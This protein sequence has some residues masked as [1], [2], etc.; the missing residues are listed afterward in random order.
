[1]RLG[2]E[3]LGAADSV[4]SVQEIRADLTLL[5]K[6]IEEEGHSVDRASRESVWTHWQETNQRAW[7][8]LNACWRRN[9]DHLRSILDGARGRVS[10]GDAPGARE[11]VR[12]F[13]SAVG[14]HECSHRALRELRA[15]AAAIWAEAEVLARARREAHR[16]WAGERVE[17]W[18]RARER[19]RRERAAIEGEIAVLERQA[20]GAPT[21][22][23]AA[24]LRGRLAE[25]RK[26]LAEVDNAASK[27]DQ[28]IDAAEA[29]LGHS[30]APGHSGPP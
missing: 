15:V 4:E 9:E 25:R 23:G 12:T 19:V 22:V 29:T 10:A 20:A 2:D 28:Q 5:R 11:Q 8:A 6:R 17:G 13:H 7:Q 14:T 1:L 26:A 18:K 30:A 3:A 24:L 27:L 16:R 21:D